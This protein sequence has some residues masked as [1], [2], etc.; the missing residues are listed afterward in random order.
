MW[1]LLLCVPVG[2]VWFGAIRKNLGGVGTRNSGVDASDQPIALF[3]LALLGGHSF[4]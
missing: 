2:A 4:P 3:F 1:L